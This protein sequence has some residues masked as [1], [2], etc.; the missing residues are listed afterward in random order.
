[1]DHLLRVEN[2]VFKMELELVDQD[3][4]TAERMRK[5]FLQQAATMRANG[6]E[7]RA[8]YWD[9]KAQDI[10]DALRAKQ[11]REQEQ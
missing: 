5:A 7:D 10:A 8:S 6:E 4:D 3:P 1:M 11:A 2:I 9:S